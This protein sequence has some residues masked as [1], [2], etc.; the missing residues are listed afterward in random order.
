MIKHLKID[1]TGDKKFIYLM[2]ND[3]TFNMSIEECSNFKYLESHD[4]IMYHARCFTIS[5]SDA[6]AI[7]SKID[8][9]KAFYA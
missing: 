6:K 8:E 9:L 4:S 5:K 1:E 7:F 3:L 2:L